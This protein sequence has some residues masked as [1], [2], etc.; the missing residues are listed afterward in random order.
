MSHTHTQ[1]KTFHLQLESSVFNPQSVT[2]N[3]ISEQVHTNLESLAESVSLH[4]DF[5][6]FGVRL[7]SLL[8]HPPLQFRR[9][10]QLATDTL[11]LLPGLS[12]NM[13]TTD[14]KDF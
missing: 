10:R 4:R 8:S 7:L 3:K 2:L 12:V 13:H 14:S 9:E 5:T 1:C 6:E 11:K